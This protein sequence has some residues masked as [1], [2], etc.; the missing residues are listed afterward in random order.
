[1]ILVIVN[2]AG[3]FFDVMLCQNDEVVKERLS[4]NS[5]FDCVLPDFREFFYF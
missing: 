3:R 2:C 1:M 4:N 5:R